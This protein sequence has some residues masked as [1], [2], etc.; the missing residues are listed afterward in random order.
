MGAILLPREHLAMF[1]DIFDCH[2]WGGGGVCFQH[3]EDNETL[4]NTLQ[5]NR[6]SPMTKN[7]SAKN[8]NSAKVEKL[9]YCKVYSSAML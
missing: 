2:G 1:R 8:I 6:Q 3:P 9:F 7:H 4:L 5:C